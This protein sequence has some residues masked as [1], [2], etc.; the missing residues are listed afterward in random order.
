VEKKPWTPEEIEILTKNFRN[1]RISVEAIAKLTGRSV[2]GVRM[3]ACKLKLTKRR[4]NYYWKEWELE[5]LGENWGVLSDAVICRRLGR[6]L[7]GI[8]LKIKRQ[9]TGLTKRSNIYTA[10][11]VARIM[12]IACSKSVVGYRDKGYIQGEK[13]TWYQGANKVWAFTY[14]ALE[15]CLRRRPWLCRWKRMDRNYFRSVVQEEWDKDPWYTCNQAAPLLGV[16]DIN[17]VHRYIYRGWLAAER[18]PGG[19]HQGTWIIRQSA[20]DA[21]LENDPRPAHVRVASLK[22]R[23]KLAIRRGRPIRLLTVWRL[24]C[25]KCHRYV[26]INANP[27]LDG[28]EIKRAFRR[29]YT[30]PSCTHKRVIFIERR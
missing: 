28:N 20:I 19:P 11:E 9:L 26:R 1:N 8:R 5:Y 10:W 7:T 27:N 4:P 23:H 2:H 30:R 12:G 18:S 29:D 22:S 13:A 14:E 3:E 21:M 25:R 16:I 24:R 6:T 17:A 15:E